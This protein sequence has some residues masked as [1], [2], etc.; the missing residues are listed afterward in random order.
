MPGRVAHPGHDVTLGEWM[1]NNPSITL[2]CASLVATLYAPTVQPNQPR[3]SPDLAR[4][5][6][7]ADEIVDTIL[8]GD[9]VRLHA[10][11]TGEFL[12]IETMAA[13]QP[14]EGTVVILH[15]RGLHPD[16]VNVVHPLRVG[17]PHHGWNTLAVQLPVL[18][19]GAKY[20]DYVEIF[21]A[22]GPRIDAAL[23]RAREMSPGRVVLLAHSCGFHMA[24]HWLYQ[25][26][27]AEPGFDAFVGIGM[28]ATDAGQPM[29]EPF[30]L[31]R[32]RMPVLDLF[33]EDDYNAVHEL[34]PQR[35]AALR[36]AG[37]PRNAQWVVDD[38]GHYFV[39]RGE[40]LTETVAR[41]L[42]TLSAGE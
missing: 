37:N 9:A 8:D 17:L 34:A 12:A 11:D 41:W 33:G 25:R 29:R 30:V 19:G 22:A 42:Q 36:R 20:N 13:V 35:L 18:D 2:L 24:Q 5:Q 23:A 16:W 32:L 38:A 14:A 4:E 10:A 21:D 26:G 1:P 15:G 40:I 39:D 6:R 31:D 3:Q 28:G 27:T 7:I